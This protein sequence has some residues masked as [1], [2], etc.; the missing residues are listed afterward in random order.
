LKLRFSFTVN[1]ID[2]FLKIYN[3]EILALFPLVHYF[4]FGYKVINV[5]ILPLILHLKS[6]FKA[7]LTFEINE[8]LI[9][10]NVRFMI[11]LSQNIINIFRLNHKK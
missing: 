4:S 11:N 3:I 2:V 10:I 6:I 8:L 5:H 7:Y 1:F 9:Q